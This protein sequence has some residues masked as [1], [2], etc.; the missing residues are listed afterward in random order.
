MR[1]MRQLLVKP[2]CDVTRLNDY[3]LKSRDMVK[4]VATLSEMAAPIW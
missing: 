1:S 4:M 3:G 2:D